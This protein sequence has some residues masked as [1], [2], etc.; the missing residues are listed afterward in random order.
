MARL[1]DITIRI[2][3]ESLDALRA[4]ADR[5]ERAVERF[6]EA[7]EQCNDAVFLAGAESADTC[8]G[9]TDANIGRAVQRALDAA[10]DNERC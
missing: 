7:L 2:D 3:Q 1:D 5:I 10:E 8:R 4:V 9:S 6:E